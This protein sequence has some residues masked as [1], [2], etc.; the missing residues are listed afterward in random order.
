[1]SHF[2]VLVIGSNPEKLLS[3]YHEFEC[4]GIDDQYIQEEDIT[5]EIRGD[6]ET[7]GSVEEAVIYNMGDDIIIS[8][9]SEI[10]LEF[11]HKYGYAVVR[12]GELIKAV[13]R[14]NPNKKWDWY[15][16]GGRWSGFLLHKNGSRVD[17]LAKGDL[18]IAGMISEKAISAKRAYESFLSAIDGHEFPRTFSS[19]TTDE[20][21]IDKAREIYHAQPAIKS[22]KERDVYRIFGC[23]VEHFGDNEQDFVIRQSASAL[24]T[25]AIIH[26]NTWFAKGEMG[27]FGMSSD[28]VSQEQW[29]EK[30]AE[31]ISGLPD[32]EVLSVYDCHI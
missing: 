15:V 16:R 28:E 22:L 17:S 11:Q 7:H 26:Q 10:D 27:W 25:Y 13:R 20:P 5:D 19:I 31:L 8:D 1:M 24:S 14:T 23:T 4:T 29:N 12:D 21:D 2:A 6:I 18:D 30:V 3:P 9:E 32:H